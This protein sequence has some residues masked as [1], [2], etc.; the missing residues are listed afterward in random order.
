[1]RREEESN[2]KR[3]ERPVG[4]YEQKGVDDASC[5]KL[6]SRAEMNRSPVYLHSELEC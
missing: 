4:M 2:G 5:R 3:R 6:F 1:V